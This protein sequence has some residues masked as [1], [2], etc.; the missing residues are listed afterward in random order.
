MHKSPDLQTLYFEGMT[1]SDDET[2]VRCSEMVSAV[3]NIQERINSNL[4]TYLNKCENEL[5][6]SF[7]DDALNAGELFDLG[8]K[9]GVCELTGM[10]TELIV[11]GFKNSPK[12][13]H[14]CRIY[15]PS[16]LLAVFE[17]VNFYI[18]GRDVP[19][20]TWQEMEKIFEEDE[21]AFKTL[22]DLAA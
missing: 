3:S 2:S 20:Q 4:Q 17:L 14:V 5:A 9:E 13:Y 22:M 8:M 18:R 19:F 7:V 1:S 21:S 12:R 11:L 15:Y 16:L 6:I 10:R